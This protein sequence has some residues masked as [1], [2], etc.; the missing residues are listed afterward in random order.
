MEPRSGVGGF[1]VGAAVAFMRA[2]AFKAA[3]AAEDDGGVVFVAGGAGV[4]GAGAVVLF[5]S[6]ALRLALQAR[7]ELDEDELERSRFWSRFWRRPLPPRP[8]CTLRSKSPERILTQTE[9]DIQHQ[10]N[11]GPTFG[12]RNMSAITADGFLCLDTDILASVVG[13]SP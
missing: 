11:I 9:N 4:D 12:S 8:T 5:G 1:A 13:E 6:A 10:E 2:G 7:E 3:G